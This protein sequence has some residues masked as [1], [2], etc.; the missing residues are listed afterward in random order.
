MLQR[1]ISEIRYLAYL[2]A[3]SN[4][5]SAKTGLAPHGS[6]SIDLEGVATSDFSIFSSVVVFDADIEPEV[7][8]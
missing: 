3:L 4:L 5:K 1:G 7:S 8:I 2:S 6:L